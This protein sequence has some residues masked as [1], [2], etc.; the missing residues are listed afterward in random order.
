MTTSEKLAKCRELDDRKIY[1]VF[2]CG[3]DETICLPHTSDSSEWEEL[4][5]AYTSAAIEFL[6][7][8]QYEGKRLRVSKDSF[9]QNW[10]GGKY[11]KCRQW[12]FVSG[13]VSCITAETIP[14]WLQEAMSRADD[15]GRDAL[16][17]RLAEIQAAETAEMKEYAEQQV[18]ELNLSENGRLGT[19]FVCVYDS[20]WAG[21]VRLS[22]GQGLDVECN[23]FSQ[24]DSELQ[25]M[26]D[27]LDEAEESQRID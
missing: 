5:A 4:G 13:K 17:K 26:V 12:G 15:L 24:I 20:E 1:K 14:A 2:V 19:E 8:L 3:N 21:H 27:W 18:K 11:V 16:T 23:S 9:F 10:N 25:E 7:Q 6:E 22:D